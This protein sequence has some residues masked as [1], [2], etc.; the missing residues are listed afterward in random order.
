MIQAKQKS[1]NSF[2]QFNA[3]TSIEQITPPLS[4]LAHN[5]DSLELAQEKIETQFNMSES[6]TKTTPWIHENFS[7]MKLNNLFSYNFIS[8]DSVLPMRWNRVHPLSTLVPPP[9]RSHT[10][11]CIANCLFMF[12]GCSETQC[13]NDLYVF[14]S[15]TYRWQHP[16]TFGNIPIPRRAHSASVYKHFLIIFGGTCITM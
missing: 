14:D 7:N 15:N 11:N 5:L 2:C 16:T 9:V 8:S 13:V 6:L 10:M 3:K 4:P 12:G 1:I